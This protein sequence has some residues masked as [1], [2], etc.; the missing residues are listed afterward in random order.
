MNNKN[1]RPDTAGELYAL[2]KALRDEVSRLTVQI[3]AMRRQLEEM[4]KNEN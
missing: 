4:K 1:T 2:V 3:K